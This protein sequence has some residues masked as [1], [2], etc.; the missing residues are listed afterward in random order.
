MPVGHYLANLSHV[1]GDIKEVSATSAILYPEIQIL[2]ASGNPTGE[3]IKKTSPDQVSITGTLGGEHDGAI[4]TIHAQSGPFI[5]R[6]VWFVDGEDGTIEVRNRPE[7]GPFGVFAT[8]NEMRVTLN[9]EE[10]ELDQREEDR[11]GNAGK[12]WLEYA[13]GDEGRYETLEHSVA[14]WRVLDGALRSIAA[15]GIKVQ[16]S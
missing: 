14:V 8:S 2:D 1:L 7:K 12:A 4:V 3:I 13:K 11:L 15:G 5:S 16:V 6:F 10:V 9:N